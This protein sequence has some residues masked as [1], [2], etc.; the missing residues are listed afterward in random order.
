[1]TQHVGIEVFQIEL[2]KYD[3]WKCS[4]GQFT[5]SHSRLVLYLEPNVDKFEKVEIHLFFIDCVKGPTQCPS[6]KLKIVDLKEKLEYYKLFHI[7]AGF[8]AIGFDEVS[9]N[10]ELKCL[11]YTTT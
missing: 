10:G 5:H 9:I 7:S 11:L 1:M 3:G 6:C 4:F 2:S 8:E